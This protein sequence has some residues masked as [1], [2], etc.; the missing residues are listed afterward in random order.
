MKATIFILLLICQAM[1]FAADDTPQSFTYQGRIYKSNGVDPLEAV[2]VEFKVQ[3]RSPDG[4]CLLYEETHLRDMTGTSGIF[5]LIVGDGTNTG[6][7]AL[8]LAQVFDNSTAKTGASGCTYTPTT[9]DTRRLRFSYYDGIE[10]VALP[11]D[12]TIRSVP[13][14]LNSSQLQGVGKDGFVRVVGNVTQAKIEGLATNYTELMALAGGTS[15]LYS[16][17]S[18]LPISGGVLNMSSAGVKVADTPAATD[19]AI[20]RNYADSKIAGRTVDTS[21]LVNNQALTWNAT[22]SKWVPTTLTT[23]TV[24]S[25]TA[26]DGLTGGTISSSGSIALATTGTAGTYTKVTTDAYGRVIS[27]TTLSDSDFPTI[28]TAG[29]VSGSAIS[30]GTIGGSTSMNTT[31]NITT[32]GNVTA[33]N[34]SATTISGQSLRIFD[35]GN[36]RKVTMTIPG[37][38]SADY[39][40]VLPS[41]AGTSGQILSTDG[42]GNL[43]WTSDATGATGSA[44]GDLS[45]TYPNPTVA[46]LQGIAVSSTTPASGQF[47]RN[48]GTTWVPT[49]SNISDLKTSAGIT[50]FPTS[51]TAAQTLNYS[52]ITDLFTCQNI[53]I[54]SSSIT[55]LGTA[56][57][58]SVAASGDASVTEIVLGSDTRLT[59][60][61]APS[62]SASGDL[63]GTYP[64]PTLTTTGVSLGTYTK[65]TVD[66][67]GRVTAGTTL[68][69]SDIPSIDW[70]KISSLSQ[71][72]DSARPT[73]GTSG[74]IYIATDV[75]KIYRDNGTTWDVLA[76]P[77]DTGTTANKVVQ[78]DANAKLP[79]VD[80]S[81]L[82]NLPVPFGN[83]QV[84]DSSGSWTPPTGIT[85]VYVQV[86]GGGG[87]GGSGTPATLTSGGGAG[88]GGGGHGAG[89]FTL[90]SSSAVT[91]T[92]GAGGTVPGTSGQAGGSGGTS[93]FGGYISADGGSGGGVNTPILT[94]GGS[95]LATLNITGTKGQGSNAAVGGFGGSASNGGGIALGATYNTPGQAGIAPGGGG[96]GGYGVI[97]TWTAGGTGAAGRVIVWW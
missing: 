81:Q 91:V 79:A 45:G 61:R 35:S 69:A 80:A 32:T 2:S 92:V 50:Q 15:T 21:G 33:S 9:G 51:C 39:S 56:A 96:G 67:K 77:T 85:K 13:Y 57:T 73:A 27:G 41:T 52:S 44:G 63:A 75:Y 74:R 6:V 47:M 64:S 3:V 89:I 54:A 78:L 95:S 97:G 76:A 24:T 20:N 42:N 72:L 31:G 14:A 48:N 19:H 68:T 28:T 65:V 60:S 62:G 18:D 4:L 86:W 5:S 34:L 87:A 55:G 29:K 43:S 16:K 90:S 22:T 11:T 49:Y 26:G 58:K 93:S 7:S 38:I 82:K 30:S 40:L 36:N 1:A 71:G 17:A 84:F 88:G 46:K 10:T 12:Q 8:T 59:N 83:M 66:T 25:I 37:A 23:G 70:S 53:S 94:I